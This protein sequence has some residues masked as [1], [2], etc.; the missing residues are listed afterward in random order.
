ME[1]GINHV[2][3]FE[4]RFLIRISYV[5]TEADLNGAVRNG[6]LILVGQPVWGITLRDLSTDGSVILHFLKVITRGLDSSSSGTGQWRVALNKV[7]NPRGPQEAEK[8]LTICC[9]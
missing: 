1:L 7:T 2:F 6:N 3:K 5:A 9:Q 4:Y 8:P